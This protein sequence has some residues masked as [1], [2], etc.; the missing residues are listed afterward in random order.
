MRVFIGLGEVAGR[1]RALKWGFEHLGHP[2]T[3]INFGP[4][5]FQY[6]GDDSLFLTR[7]IRG[8]DSLRRRLSRG[9]VRPLLVL[10]DLFFRV[11]LFLQILFSHDLFIYGYASSFWDYRLWSFLTHWDYR[12]IRFFG[13]TLICQFQGSDSRPPYLNGAYVSGPDFSIAKCASDTVAQKKRLRVVGRWANA[14]VDI[15]PQGYF[16]EQPYYVSLYVGLPSGPFDVVRPGQVEAPVE[17]SSAKPVRILHAPSSARYKGTLQIREIVKGLQA[18]GLAIEFIELQD[19]SNEEVIA[20]IEKADLVVDQLYCDY[21]LNGLPAEA[22]WWGKP[23]L[24]GGYSA[25]LW[26]RLIPAEF[27]P[28][29][30]YCHPAEFASRLELLVVDADHRLRLGAAGYDYI[31][32]FHH[33]K[34]VAANY[35]KIAAGEA[36]K[37]WLYDPRQMK[38]VWG[39]F[40]MSEGSARQITREMVSKFG[41]KSL[42]LA[43]KLE[44]EEK[45]VN[46]AQEN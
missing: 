34:I 5:P 10:P 4:H 23:V 26:A 32:R 22:L 6:G 16:H 40:F 29:V 37:E 31:R 30:V 36:P 38:E 18:K 42:E 7:A 14:I 41:R 33:P 2:T 3:F 13:K 17:S 9:I 46:W 27:L 19:K 12:L 44:L 11:T 24:S 21:A 1:N 35:L 28:P 45:I 43:D 15:P 8:V 20:E 25:D 39:G